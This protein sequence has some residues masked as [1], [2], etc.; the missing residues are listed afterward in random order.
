MKV[1]NLYLKLLKSNIVIVMVYVI[2]FLGLAFL[3]NSSSESN[4]SGYENTKVRISFVSEDDSE[5]ID[6]LVS[7][8]SNYA[9]FIEVEERLIEDAIYLEQVYMHISI[10]NGFTEDFLAGNNPKI[11][12][13][14]NPQ[15]IN[16]LMTV[17][18]AINS[19]LN[20]V[21]IYKNNTDLTLNEI[22]ELVNN[23]LSKEIVP[24]V[25]IK[26]TA[27]LEGMALF[28]NYLAYIIL[29]ITILVIGVIM[30]RLKNI[31]LSRRL[32]I[33]PYPDK[34]TNLEMNLG[35]GFIGVSLL[36]LIFLISLVFFP[37]L[38]LSQYG[39]FMMTNTAIFIIVGISIGYLIGLLIKNEDGLSAASN[40][41]ALGLAFL[42]GAFIPQYL[43][44][45]G[46]LAV[47]HVFP[48][49]YF[50]NNN[51][52]IASLTNFTWDSLKQVYFFML[53]QLLFAILFFFLSTLI[54]KKQKTKEN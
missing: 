42:T 41:I 20:H 4:D 43:L 31:H 6:G 13:I 53:V 24:E 9:K 49:Y 22:L 11:S 10:P 21:T 29:A 28:F 54:S 16:N 32:E 44:G 8:I 25:L 35:H 2:I 36:V 50:I 5:L 19:Y 37:D 1:F 46:I 18:Q 47:A 15:S 14:T 45:K 7:H 34:K 39:L 52:R 27:E 38:L 51:L 40:V 33:S 48:S 30:L 12:K 17:N 26:D 23:D 3:F